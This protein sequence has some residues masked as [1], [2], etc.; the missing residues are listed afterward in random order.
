[1]I[2][3]IRRFLLKRKVAK[4]ARKVQVFN[5]NTAK[6]ALVLYNFKSEA[7]EKEIREFC[8]FLKEEGIKV[9]S[10]AYIPKKIK[11]GEYTPL[12]ELNYLYFD[13]TEVNWLKIPYSDRIKEIIEKDFHLLID[14]NLEDS[15]PIQWISELSKAY[16]K[17]GSS[18]GYKSESCDLLMELKEESI[19]SLQSQCRV[20]LR[21]I[22][23]KN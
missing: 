12:E 14:F 21:M 22:N 10:L 3:A 1:M 18:R 11:E 9:S 5:L 23:Q 15:F 4:Q 2:K 16:F 6:T 17:V 7:R 19:A 20:Y 8:R 13:K